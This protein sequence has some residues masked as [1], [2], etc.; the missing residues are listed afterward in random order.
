MGPIVIVGAGQAAAQFIDSVRKAGYGGKLILIGDEPYIPYQRPPLSK[1]FLGDKLAEE[2]LSIK[3]VLF[4]EKND[5]TL[6]LGKTVTA[7]NRSDKTISLNEET[8]SYGTL[9]L[10]TGS[11]VRQLPVPGSELCGVHYVRTLDDIKAAKAQL[12]SVNKIAIIGAGFIGLEVA[13]VLKGLD[14]QVTVVEAQSRVME[15]VIPPVLSSWYQNLHGGHGVN[16]LLSQQVESILG[17]NGH[18]SG[19]SLASGDTIETDMVFIGIGI[20]ANVELGCEVGLDEDNGI[21]VND[22]CQTS[23][24]DIYA[25]GECCNH[26]TR[27]SSTGRAR[28]ES[29]QNAAD[30]AIVAAKA[31]MG[32]DV[33]YDDVPWFWSEQY[34]TRLQIAGLSTGYDQ[35]VT[36]GDMESGSFSILYFR[37][38]NLIA[39]DSMNTVKDHMAARKLIAQG[40]KVDPDEVANPDV[41]LKS[42]LPPK[43]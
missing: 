10:A 40:I 28:L 37:E 1:G 9:I 20:L 29:V 36:R 34:E 31:L 43:T 21:T 24:E 30:Q 14:K 26:P 6:M 38:G 42:F 2:R 17:N 41:T 18:V 12:E 32:E 19:I 23:D 16:I 39:V 15:R 27:Y 3:P 25:I 5:V 4:Y 7:I 33:S 13:A 11:R 8:C 35:V 22:K